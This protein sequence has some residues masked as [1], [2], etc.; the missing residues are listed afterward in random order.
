MKI[1]LVQRHL[2]V[3]DKAYNIG[4]MEKAVREA[5]GDL[6]VFG[7][8]ALTGY[9]CRD[10]FFLM[11]EE[12]NGP[13]VRALADIAASTGKH[14]LFGMPLKGDVP[15][16]LY[17]SAVMVSPDGRAQVYDKAYPANFGPFEEGF[18]FTKGREPVMFECDGHLIGVIVCYDVFHPELVRAYA[19]AGAEAV[20]CISSS[21]ATSRTMFEMVL[22][23]RAVEDTV[24]VLYC[25]QVGTQL[26]MPFFGG[27]QA[28]SPRGNQIA[29]A[30]YF[31]EGQVTI[32][33]DLLE[34]DFARR[35][36][37]T[38]RDCGCQ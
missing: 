31:K 16:I 17:N 21:P 14:I 23:A 32:E 4:V 18:Y 9:M 5:E 3:G 28:Y 38:V 24:Y 2:K 34:L 35:M 11:A 22:P 27:S 26:N 37:P 6:V 1:T 29:H 25:N 30:G 15:G 8:M 13:S 7:E 33:I 12:E 10:L 36:R 19:L 20:V